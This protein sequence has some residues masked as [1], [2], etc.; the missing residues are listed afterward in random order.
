MA[1]GENQK[2]KMLYLVKIFSEETDDQHGLTM[3]EIIRRLER[4]GVTAD[5]KTLY[6]DFEELERFGLDIIG[7]QESRN[8]YYHLGSREFELAELKLLVDSVQAAKFIT[9]KKSKDLIKKLESLVSQYD[10][11]HL[12]RQVLLSGRVKTVNE[13]IYYNVD[14]IHE[15]INAG[16]QIRFHYFQWNTKKKMELRHDGKWYQVSPWCMLWDDEYYYMVA[17]DAESGTLKHYRADKMLDI[18][19]IDEKREGRAEYRNFDTAKYARQL[20]GMYAG[21]E[22]R[23]VLKCEN[24][25]AGVLID[26][27]GKDIFLTTLDDSHCVAHV[28]VAVSLQFL[29]WL[30]ALG[31]GVEI[32][33]PPE[34]VEKMRE[35]A[36]RLSRQY[37]SS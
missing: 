2:L 14:Q 18:S 29:G 36:R 7:Q 21:E 22:T 30:F 25:M 16:K 37:L 17:Y 9:Q 4:Y 28:D 26:R 12:H 8:Y 27:F 32:I 1:K 35:E 10:A 20:F 15:A 13:K 5:R 24:E 11:K 31:E 19:V 23:V 3:P 33:D 34:A 6:K